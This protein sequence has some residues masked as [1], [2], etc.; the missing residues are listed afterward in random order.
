MRSVERNPNDE[1]RSENAAP[2]QS[3]PAPSAT[4]SHGPNGLGGGKPQATAFD[5]RDLVPEPIFCCDADGH[6]V[7]VNNA[8][9]KLTGYT[10]VELLGQPFS[11]LISS[12]NRR[13]LSTFFIRQ[14]LREAVES[15]RDVPILTREG[16]T[17]WV[18]LRLRRVRT[19]HGR[20]GYVACAHDLHD[21]VF[22][23]ERL[24]S[25]ARD[26]HVKV[27]E[28]TSA[29]RLKSEFLS[30]MSEEVRTPMDGL[31]SMTRLLLESNL[32]RDQRTFAEVIQSS[33][34][35][36]LTLVA[37]I[38]DFS[39]I[40]A[41]KLEV[42]SLDFDLRVTVDNTA[43]VLAPV[44][45]AKRINLV[46]NVHSEVPSHLRG[47]PG[48][49]RQVLSHVG[50]RIIQF[51]DRGEVSILTSLVEET[52]HQFALRFSMAYSGNTPSE[53]LDELLRVFGQSD[54][55]T[56]RRL[57]AEAL[58][59]AL[60]R[61]LITLMGGD[62]GFETQGGGGTLWFQIPFKRQEE[63]KPVGRLPEVEI[64]GM[65][66]LVADPS[67]GMRMA[68]TEML[69]SWGCVAD[70]AEDGPLAVMLMRK[71][72]QQG[73]PYRVA[74][75]DMQMPGADGETLARQIRED[76]SLD[77]TLLMLLTSL[78]RR[79][80][81]AR[82]Q[83]C[84]YSAYLVKPFEPT[85]L[86]EALVEVVYRGAPAK[87]E[88]VETGESPAIV[89][90]HSVAEKRRE[91][92]RILVVDD[93]P[94]NQLVAV[95]ALRRAGYQPEAAASASEAIQ[96]HA[97]H[98]FDLIFMDLE[99][100]DF[101]GIEATREIFRME[102]GTGRRTPVV[103]ITGHDLPEIRQRCLEVGMLD[104]LTKPIP[105]E[106]MSAGV[107]RWT[108][109][110]VKPAEDTSEDT[111]AGLPGAAEA[112]ATTSPETPENA[113]EAS[114]S[115]SL[116]TGAAG[117]TTTSS[118]ESTPAPVASNVIPLRTVGSRM[119]PASGEPP[120]DEARLES[121]SM[122]NPELRNILIRTF[123]NHIRP[124]LGRLREVALAGDMQAVEFEA[125][126][127]KGMCATIGAMC[128]ADA[129]ARIERLGSEKRQEPIPPM[130]DY[131]EIEVARVEAV[132]GQKARAA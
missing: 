108:Q 99:L 43:G 112:A 72:A 8:A 22:E 70:E 60:S 121:S 77:G 3:D 26:L 86:Y 13:K 118:I 75:I 1:A 58:S 52:P 123:V 129:F 23:I 95:A 56:C 81:A 83:E 117:D 106:V 94:V 103:A 45:N 109:P 93:N 80:D 114:A 38:L 84:G 44:A 96:S 69:T 27:A 124:R 82:A 31:L 19:L 50:R 91:R 116:G 59:I 17:V 98:R 15:E 111:V 24:R 48:R 61:Q 73:R 2:E 132:M 88:K 40:E 11:M 110:A 34:E 54:P 33:G 37:D 107:D 79:G 102:E 101:D 76:Q 65:R 120:L 100:P 119:E 55:S 104:M 49:L 128:C 29:T 32:D 4:P 85:Y 87:T 36:L 62:A 28:A 42:S 63:R 7:W 18:G 51:M 92:L 66:V 46:R 14:H 122:G 105:L 74:L 10:T 71:A 113:P 35:A 130:L 131:A 64:G 89:T 41:G 90:R 20:V 97:L 53:D 9:E 47:D 127:L 39:N 67:I 25:E 6:F 68:L 125:H 16:R 30:V 57:G 115:E 5:P 21:M 78:G 126:G 12:T